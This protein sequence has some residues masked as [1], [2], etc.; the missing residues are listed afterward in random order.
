MT[1]EGIKLTEQIAERKRIT[2]DWYFMGALKR[3]ITEMEEREDV[4]SAM[5][6]LRAYERISN[7]VL[8]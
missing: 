5:D 7:R 8:R 2:A 3:L 4:A 6:L 1:P